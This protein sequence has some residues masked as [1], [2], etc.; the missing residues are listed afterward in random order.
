MSLRISLDWKPFCF[1][2]AAWQAWHAQHLSTS[3]SY[4]H[5]A[6]RLLLLQLLFAPLSAVKGKVMLALEN[7]SALRKKQLRW[8]E[9]NRRVRVRMGCKDLYKCIE[10]Q[11]LLSKISMTLP[12]HVWTCLMSLSFCLDF[13]CSVQFNL[14]K[15]D[16]CRIRLPCPSIILF[17]SPVVQHIPISQ[18]SMAQVDWVGLWCTQPRANPFPSLGPLPLH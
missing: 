5:H 6:T 1:F 7:P 18:C 13:L 3:F 9:G 12:V 16:Q 4:K 8:M 2:K 17:L 14:L 10:S 11:I 15:P